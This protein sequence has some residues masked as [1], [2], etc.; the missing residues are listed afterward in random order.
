MEKNYNSLTDEV[1]QLRK[2]VKFLRKRYQESMAENTDLQREH[3]ANNQDLLDTIRVQDKESKL[4]TGIIE[5]LLSSNELDALKGA[6]EW[7]DDQKEYKI[8][9]FLMK[10]KKVKF[11]QLP[12]S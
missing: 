4:L 5:M 11:P 10:Y 8:P 9:P 12:R 1:V 3:Q 6:S 2:L 7:N